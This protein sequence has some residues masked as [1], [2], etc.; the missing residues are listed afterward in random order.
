MALDKRF[1]KTCSTRCG[2]YHSEEVVGEALRHI[3]RDKVILS[4]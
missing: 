3:D 1:N 2:L 4:T